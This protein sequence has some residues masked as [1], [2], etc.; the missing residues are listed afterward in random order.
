MNKERSENKLYILF[1]LIF[2]IMFGIAN[3]LPYNEN[4][5]IAGLNY[6]LLIYVVIMSLTYLL[7]FLIYFFSK[8]ENIQTKD[9]GIK[10]EKIKNS[11]AIILFFLGLSYLYLIYS[12]ENSIYPYSGSTF[13]R[14]NP[15]IHCPYFVFFCILFFC[16]VF[17][18]KTMVKEN[19]IFRMISVICA[20]L[21][22]ALLA[23]APNIYLDRSGKL[24]H[25]DAYVNSIINIANLNPFDNYNS[26]IYGHYGL[27]FLPFVKLL[28]NNY[29]AIAIAISIF[30]LIAFFCAF[31]VCNIWIKNDAV[32]LA[33][34]FSI[35]GLVTLLYI[36]GQYFQVNPHRLLFPLITIF[37]ITIFLKYEISLKK[38]FIIEMIVG[39]FGIIWNIETGLFCLVVICTFH[40]GCRFR[41]NQNIKKI[42]KEIGRGIIFSI[43]Y[44]ILAYLIICFYN[45]LCGSRNLLS[46]KQFIY[47]IG[48]DTYDITGLRL[49]I[50]TIFSIYML[51]IIIFSYAIFNTFFHS[52]NEILSG[53]KEVRNKD[54]AQMCIAVSGL[55]S[56]TYFM[57]RA[58]YSNIAISW[59]QM[60][61]ILGIFGDSGIQNVQ[62]YFNNK[63]NRQGLSIR[64]GGKL[65]L[66]FALFSLSLEGAL[67]IYRAVEIR[68]ESSWDTTSFEIFANEVEE[69]VPKN[70]IA[71]GTGVSELYYQLGWDTGIVV[72][73][74]PDMNE[75]NNKKVREAIENQPYF[76]ARINEEFPKDN[77]EF[78]II[79]ENDKLVKSFWIGNSQYGLY[80][81]IE[82]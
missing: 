44:V 68:I 71:F 5:M 33:T 31:Y 25:A 1:G 48:S 79:D 70:T 54:I 41:D 22:C 67:Y 7:F 66:L 35:I 58:A 21:L 11:Y 80:E 51:Q 30:C 12:G 36:G 39:V 52:K 10:K 59:I 37:I 3:Q 27:I 16:F 19:R 29:T 40:I 78:Q 63:D 6:N 60:V 2:I 13:I 73:D 24:Y 45:F 72:T 14:N 64:T 4:G 76:F 9:E 18:A 23:Y 55:C 8:K 50:P 17:L 75:L 34:V 49:Q 69:N 28:G 38:N 56:L 62:R 77:K 46:I 26:S 61:V 82:Q 20:S 57:N 47:P 32:Y 81:P 42:I 15:T 53:N 65:V 74:W 43:M